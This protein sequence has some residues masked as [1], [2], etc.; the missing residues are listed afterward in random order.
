MS[1]KTFTP[2][3][4]VAFFMDHKFVVSKRERYYFQ[5]YEPEYGSFVCGV[6]VD[7]KGEHIRLTT[8]WHDVTV[9]EYSAIG[10]ALEDTYLKRRLAM[11]CLADKLALMTTN[12]DEVQNVNR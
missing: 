1:T 7:Q 4:V 10:K 2:S 3:A 6:H 11:L 5:V 9:T 12:N 8:E